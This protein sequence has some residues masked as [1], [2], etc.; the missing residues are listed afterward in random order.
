MEIKS[1][2]KIKPNAINYFVK[3]KDIAPLFVTLSSHFIS[4]EKQWK[5][6]LSV[7]KKYWKQ[8]FYIQKNGLK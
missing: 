6:T 7:V 3:K 8:K 2:N 4:Y 1:D 5:R